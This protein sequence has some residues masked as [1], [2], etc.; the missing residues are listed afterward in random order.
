MP[1]LSSEI[2]AGREPCI[3]FASL[4]AFLATGEIEWPEKSSYEPHVFFVWPECLLETICSVTHTYSIFEQY[5]FTQLYRPESIYEFASNLLLL[6]ARVSACPTGY[7]R[8]ELR[9]YD[10]S[11]VAESQRTAENLKADILETLGFVSQKILQTARDSRC[12]AIIGF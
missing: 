4:P 2:L 9:I 7:F 12:L 1:I 6:M 10:N 3:H 8:S 5:E 11:T